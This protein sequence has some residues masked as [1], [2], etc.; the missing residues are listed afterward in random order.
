MGLAEAGQDWGWANWGVRWPT[1]RVAFAMVRKS[2]RGI[3]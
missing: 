2:E 1:R 3:K